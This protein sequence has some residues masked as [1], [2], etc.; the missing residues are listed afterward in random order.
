VLL[1]VLLVDE[2]LLV[3][4]EL[5]LV[6]LLLELVVAPPL[7]LLLVDELLLVLLELL[8]AFEA[9]APSSSPS[10]LAL[11]PPS[12]QAV[13]VAKRSKARVVFMAKSEIHTLRLG[14]SFPLRSRTD[15][16]RRC[17]AWEKISDAT[18]ALCSRVYGTGP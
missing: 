12:A 18:A 16:N 6:L 5:L 8:L 4:L 1:L 17:I 9:P 14:W 7:P 13:Q 10:R 2:L 3:L 11:P 15:G